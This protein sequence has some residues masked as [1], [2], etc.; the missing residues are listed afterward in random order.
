MVAWR[1]VSLCDGKVAFSPL[2]Y[3]LFIAHTPSS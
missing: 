3:T 1:M 2:F